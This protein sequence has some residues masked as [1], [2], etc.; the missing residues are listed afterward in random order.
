MM[1]RILN[2]IKLKNKLKKFLILITLEQHLVKALI[3]LKEG[4]MFVLLYKKSIMVLI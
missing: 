3:F 2:K 1:I 4:I